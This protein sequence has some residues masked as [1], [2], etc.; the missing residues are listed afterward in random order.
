[1]EENKISWIAWKKVISPLLM[2][3]SV[4]VASSQV[5]KLC[6][7]SGGGDFVPTEML[8][9]AISFDPFTALWVVSMM[10]PL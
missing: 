4:L 9:G 3:D 5:I 2:V 10:P 1:M 7:P 8:F 6:F